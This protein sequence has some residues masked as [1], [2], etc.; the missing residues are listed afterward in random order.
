MRHLID[1]AHGTKGG[2]IRHFAAVE[3]RRGLK[4]RPQ[5]EALRKVPRGLSASLRVRR[6]IEIERGAI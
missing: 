3:R 1:Q 5:V 4:V 2:R 6:F